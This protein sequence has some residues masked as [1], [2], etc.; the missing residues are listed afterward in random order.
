MLN[1][2]RTDRRSRAGSE[3]PVTA[4]RR[5]SSLPGQVADAI[6]RHRAGDRTAMNDLAL[7]VSPWLHAIARGS[8]LSQSS[9]EDIAQ[10][11]LLAL[12][13]HVDTIRDPDAGVGWLAVTARR[14]AMKVARAERAVDLV[15]DFGA[16]EAYPSAAGPE[17]IAMDRLRQEILWHH[18][19]D[20][21]DRGQLILHQI[22]YGDRPDY[23][24][25]A[26]RTGIPLGSIGPTRQRTLARARKLL[27]SD[28]D[29]LACA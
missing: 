10:T 19:G 23:A 11:T 24:G 5:A 14:E 13:C 17:A 25:L 15:A 6:R 4:E 7:I 8:G 21:S 18:V 12:L 22:A 29:W 3:R 2:T 1:T 16:D 27:E 28:Q 26:R 9:A 20:L